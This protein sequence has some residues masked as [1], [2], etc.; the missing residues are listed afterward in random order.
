MVRRAKIGAAFYFSPIR[1]TFNH[2]EHA[3]DQIGFQVTGKSA[4]ESSKRFE[5]C[6]LREKR[7]S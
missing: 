7:P 3:A 4:F 6:L 1:Q 2:L 5:Y